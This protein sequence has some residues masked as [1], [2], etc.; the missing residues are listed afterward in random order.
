MKIL[1]VG[2]GIVG[3]TFAN[4]L[5]KHKQFSYNIIEKQTDFS[6]LGFTIGI[7][8]IGRQILSKI[9]LASEFDRHAKKMKNFSL[10]THHNYKLKFYTFADFYKNYESAYSHINRSTLHDILKKNVSQRI[11]FNTTV[12]S[13]KKKRGKSIV[14][15]SNGTKK[16]YDLIVGADGIN[17]DIRERYIEKHAK[18]YTGNRVWYAWLSNVQLEDGEIQEIVGD[19]HII[20]VFDDPK[21]TCAVF[22]APQTPKEYDNP[23]TRKLR[24]SHEFEHF[25]KYL[26]SAIHSVNEKEIMPLDVATVHVDKWFKDNIVLIGDAAHAMEPF[27]GIG[28]SMGMEDAYVLADE[29][30]NKNEIDSVEKVLTLFEKRRKPRIKL[31][32]KQTRERYWWISAPYPGLAIIRN[33]FAPIIP[34]SHFT[35]KYRVLLDTKP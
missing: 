32:S 15:F 16:E 3:L 26:R 18:K 1:I 35:K 9:D 27:A 14:E 31:A 2:A 25:P 6:H 24:L 13:I 19:H 10:H 4:F 8:D 30:C 23:K 33:I 5:E 34:I 20:N 17:S 11:T 12:S 7:W 21:Q 22:T 28:A 29:L